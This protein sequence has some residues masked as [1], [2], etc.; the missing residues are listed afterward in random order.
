MDPPMRAVRLLTEQPERFK[1]LCAPGLESLG[2]I[3]QWPEGMEGWCYL[4]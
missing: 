3:R 2:G 1:V 4:A